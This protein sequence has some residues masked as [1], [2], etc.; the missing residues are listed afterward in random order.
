MIFLL[1][2]FVLGQFFLNQLLQ[3]KD[4]KLK[5]LEASINQ[6]TAQLDAEQAT[7]S[8]LRLS[9]AQ[10]SA[11]LKGAQADRDDAASQLAETSAE[12]DQFRDQL[13]LLQDEKAQLTQTLNELRVE[14]DKSQELQAD[15]ERTTDLR[16]KL[17]RS[18]GW[19]SRT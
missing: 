18:C 6:L 19:P 3:G 14:A 1:V 8:E 13:F 2:V 9:V 5:S 12:R 7:N 15:L 10:L 17:E 16:A 4:S 11:D